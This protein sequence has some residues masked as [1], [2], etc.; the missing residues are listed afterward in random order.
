LVGTFDEDDRGD[1]DDGA[2]YG[3][4]E[5]NDF[6]EKNEFSDVLFFNFQGGDGDDEFFGWTAMT[7]STAAGTATTFMA[8]MATTTSSVRTVL[9]SCGADTIM[10]TFLVVN[11]L[12]TSLAARAT[13]YSSVERVGIT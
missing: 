2:T 1:E 5:K 10:M 13:I 4:Y 7:A 9:T 11:R 8:T 12:T 3:F 6:Y